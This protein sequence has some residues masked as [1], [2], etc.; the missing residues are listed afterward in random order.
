[1]FGEIVRRRRSGRGA[2]DADL[3]RAIERSQPRLPAAT[4]R[5]VSAVAQ[6]SFV[7]SDIPILPGFVQCSWRAMRRSSSSAYISSIR[8][9]NCCCS[10]ERLILRV[11]VDGLAL[12]FG[13]ELAVENAERLH[14]LDAAER[15][16]GLLDLAR[17]QAIDLGMGGERAVGRI[18]D[19]VGARPFRNGADVDL[20]QRGE[21]LAALADDAR[22]A[23][24]GARLQRGLDA[25]RADVLAARGDDDVLLAVDDLQHAVVA[26]RPTSPVRMPSA[27][28]ISADA[29]SSCQ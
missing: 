24:I 4:A 21:I 23:D 18:G 12:D 9:E 2:G 10:S 7:R 15:G 13:I 16:V 22:L 28:R 6:S 3:D 14:L 20:D 27:R 17:Q 19:A 5:Q 29:A 25:A 1:M 8:C 11:A 26:D